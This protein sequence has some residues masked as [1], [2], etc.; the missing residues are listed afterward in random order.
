[1]APHKWFVGHISGSTGVVARIGLMIAFY[2]FQ[3]GC[4][5]DAEQGQ[6]PAPSLHPK[7]GVAGKELGRVRCRSSASRQSDNLGLPLNPCNNADQ[8]EAT[9]S[10]VAADGAYD[11]MR[12]YEVVAGNGEDVRVITP[13]VT[14]VL[15][16]EAAHNPSQ[17]D[18]HIL[19]DTARGRLGGQQETGYGQRDLLKTGLM[20]PAVA[21][22]ANGMGTIGSAMQVDEPALDPLPTEA[23]HESPQMGLSGNVSGWILAGAFT[24]GTLTIPTRTSDSG[25]N[26]LAA[27]RRR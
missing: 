25:I 21:M 2:E 7:D 12:I 3:K 4:Q 10:S 16:A 18:Q 23:M 17:R 27:F 19:S 13:H 5:F 9:T 6:C 11:G 14:A 24:W 22:A 20:A 15:S 26:V 8:I 1:M